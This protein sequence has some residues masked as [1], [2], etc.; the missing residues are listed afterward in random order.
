M[1]WD[2]KG[3]EDT[4]FTWLIALLV[5]LFFSFFF[6]FFPGLLMFGEKW[7]KEKLSGDDGNIFY[8]SDSRVIVVR[9]FWDFLNKEIY[10]NGKKILVKELIESDSKIDDER[11][12]RFRDLSDEFL[13]E[14]N[15]WNDFDKAYIKI[16]LRNETTKGFTRLSRYSEFD[17]D[18]LGM[19]GSSCNPNEGVL[20]FVLIE[21]KKVVLCLE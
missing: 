12:G 10:F 16:Y 15:L 9:N 11:F 7:G 19:E 18:I 2:K 5:F 8:E 13:K 6:Y 20:Y 14:E 4:L 3:S 1:V 21:N 17:V